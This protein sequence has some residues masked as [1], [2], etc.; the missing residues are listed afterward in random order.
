MA[1]LLTEKQAVARVDAYRNAYL[2]SVPTKN[3]DYSLW[4]DVVIV[5]ASQSSVTMAKAKFKLT[6]PH[7]FGNREGYIHGG[8]TAT[9]LDGLTSAVLSII[10]RSNFWQNHNDSR[11]LAVTFF[12]TVQEGEEVIIDC[13]IDHAGRRLAAIR[14]VMKSVRDGET[15]A[16][17]L[18]DKVNTDSR[19]LSRL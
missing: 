19:E 17:C 2:S 4:R 16:V 6:F 14:G 7:T 13:Q 3:F 12:K 1:Y 10:A 11:N 9:L 8:A 15:I 5:S 18:N